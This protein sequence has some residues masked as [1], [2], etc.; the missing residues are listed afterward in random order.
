[1]AFGD[2]PVFEVDLG[3]DAEAAHDPRN[4]IPVHLDQVALPL[5][6]LRYCLWISRH[7]VVLSVRSA[8]RTKNLV[9]GRPVPGR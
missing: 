5:I 1:M 9:S 2:F 7:R 6:D 3:E 8:Y 4:R